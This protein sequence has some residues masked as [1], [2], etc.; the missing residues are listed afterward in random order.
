MNQR[1]KIVF[2][3]EPLLAY[4]FGEGGSDTIE[5]LLEG[6][7]SGV[8]DGYISHVTLTEVLYVGAQAG[9]DSGEMVEY[10]DSLNR[11]GI[12]T[13]TSD[14]AARGAADMKYRFQI[15]LGDAFA[16][17]TAFANHATLVVGADDDYDEIEEKG[18]VEILRFRD[19]AV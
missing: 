4:F 13:V 17:G 9:Y 6:V 5:A 7:Q 3:A 18:P 16:I 11:A 8:T 2:D 12:E 14:I 15:P 10:T 19:Y 1:E